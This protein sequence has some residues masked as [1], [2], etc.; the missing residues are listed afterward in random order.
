MMELSISFRKPVTRHARL[1]PSSVSL[2]ILTLWPD[3][4]F[5][6][7][8]LT[9]TNRQQRN[10]RAKHL[11]GDPPQDSQ[12]VGALPFPPICDPP[13]SDC[14]ILEKRLLLYHSSSS[15]S[16]LEPS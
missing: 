7:F 12:A 15:E 4:S 3:V 8:L 10:K 13:Q 2:G 6:Y 11:C 1:H 9:Q 16:R 5:C 14:G